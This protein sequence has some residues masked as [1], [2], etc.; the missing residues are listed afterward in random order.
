M[1][2]FVT[3]EEREIVAYRL[4]RARETLEEAEVLLHTGHVNGFVN[5]LYYASHYA[6]SAPLLTRH[7]STSKHAQV[8]A[9]FHRE[10]V[11]P[12][13]VSVEDGQHFDRL[14]ASRQKGDYTDLTRF[15]AT[16]VAH[17]L[18]CTRTF[19]DHIEVLLGQKPDGSPRC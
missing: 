5:R 8:R 10:F 18:D 6:V 19:V 13:A 15:E 2:A 17:W 1:G 7:L 14:F 11:G 4:S 9:L 12:G 3:G 16:D